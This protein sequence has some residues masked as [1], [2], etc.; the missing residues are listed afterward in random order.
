MNDFEIQ[1]LQEEIENK[2]LTFDHLLSELK[3][4]SKEEAK[5]SYIFKELTL[6]QQRKILSGSFEAVEIPAKLANIYS[7]YLSDSVFSA[8]DMAERVKYIKSI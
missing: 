4:N 8:E 1:I 5:G 3:S 6:K 2:G 7:D